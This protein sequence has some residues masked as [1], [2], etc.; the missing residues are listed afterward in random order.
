MKKQAYTFAP[1]SWRNYEPYIRDATVHEVLILG[2]DAP[3]PSKEDSFQRAAA[4]MLD[5]LNFHWI[6]PPNEGA[7]NGK[8]GANLK[9][10]GLKP[11]AS[12]IIILEPCD[13]AYYCVIELKAKDN[14]LTLEQE[15]FLKRSAGCGGVAF[16]C[17][18]LDAVEA[19]LRVLYPNK[20]GKFGR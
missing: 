7:R 19:V 18:N 12:D 14:A 3:Y 15:D 9:S 16:C 1:R 6:H 17:Y 2:E 5:M 8:T 10:K 4:K 20:F 11:G 13:K